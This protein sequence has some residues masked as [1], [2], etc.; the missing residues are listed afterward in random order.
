MINFDNAATTSVYPECLEIVRKYD[1]EIYFNPSARYMPAMSVA[2]DVR[3]AREGL[4]KLLGATKEEIYY[5]SSGTEADNWAI[6]GTIRRPDQGFVCSA[7]EHSAVYN[8]G[9][10][11]KSRGFDVSFVACNSDGS[12]NLDALK[13]AIKDNTALV[14]I[15]HVNNETGAVNDLKAISAIVKSQNPKALLHSDGVQ[16]FCKIPVNVAKL[17]VDMYTISGH[18]IHAP[19]GVAALYVKK[20]TKIH[21]YIFGGGQENGMRSST[22]NV[23]GI[24]ALTQA[25]N[26]LFSKISAVKENNLA[27]AEKVIHNLSTRYGENFKLNTDLSN[28]SGSILNVSIRGIMGEV[29]LHSLCTE[30]ILISTGSACSTKK[31]ISRIPRELGLNEAFANGT[32]RLSFSDSSTIAEADEFVEKATKIIDNLLNFRKK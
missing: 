15:M 22:E 30:G 1:S 16:A 19:K 21:P 20:G 25:A 24:L 10:E 7:C 12:V 29:L 3:R 14:S 27:I 32:I 11:L 17:G 31:G 5:T 18:K 28:W 4:A 23:A 13:A 26:T 8:V 2:M 9:K 6:W